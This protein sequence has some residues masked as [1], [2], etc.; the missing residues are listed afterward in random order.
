MFIGPFIRKKFIVC[1]QVCLG[2]VVLIFLLLFVANLKPHPGPSPFV[3]KKEF[4]HLKN[5]IIKITKYL[6]PMLDEASYDKAEGRKILRRRRQKA[7]KS[8]S[9]H[10]FSS[11][12]MKQSLSKY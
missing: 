12:K 8:F 6:I 10:G 4:L 9:C 11:Q 7:M 2:I 1:V 3:P 5:K